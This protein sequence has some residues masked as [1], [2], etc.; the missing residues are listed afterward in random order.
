MVNVRAQYATNIKT[1]NITLASDTV[2]LDSLSLIPNTILLR[3]ASGQVLDT[4]NYDILPFSSL[5]IWKK[6]PAGDSVVASFRTYPYAFANKYF[7]KDHKAY[8]KANQNHTLAPMVYVPSEV[9]PDKLIDFGSLDYNGNFSRGLSFGSNQSVILNSAFNLQL[10]GMLARDLEVTAAITDN[11]IP[12]QPEGNTQ[13]IQEFDK[14][15]IQ[16]RKG[17]HTVIVGDFDMLSPPD[18]FLKYTKKA[19]GG[20]YNGSFGFKQ[21]GTLKTHVAA[22]ISKGKFARNTLA[23]T[24]G[25]QGPYKLVGSNGETYLI[26]LANSEAVYINGQKLTRGA[27]Q[28]YVIDYNLGTVT[29]MPKRIIT[30]D[31]RIVVEFQYSERSYQRTMIDARLDWTSA[32]K[33]A[34]T[35]FDLY[36]EQDSKNQSQQQSLDDNKKKFL[37]SLGDSIDKAFYPG[38]DTVAFDINRILYERHDTGYIVGGRFFPDTFYVYSVDSNKA[39]YSI[40]FADVGLGNG[41][42]LAAQNTAN[43][44]VFIYSTPL[45][46]IR[47]TDTILVPTGQYLPIVKLVT[48]QMHQMYTLGTSYTISKGNVITAEAALS[49][50]NV[51][52]FSSKDKKNDL[53]AAGK[54]SYNGE[55]ITKSDSGK[56]KEK[57]NIEAN[58]EFSQNRFTP[59]ERY[60]NVEFARDFNLNTPTNVTYNEH[61]ASLGATYTFA[62]LGSITY[63]FRTFIQDTVYKGYENFIAG[64]FSKKNF[65]VNFSGS[66]LHSNANVGNSDFIR[67]RGEF[68]YRFKALRGIKT[69]ITFD[70]EINIYRDKLTDTLNTTLSHIWQN[71]SYFIGSSDTTK[72]QFKLEYLLRMEHPAKPN[73]FDQVEKIAHTVNFTGSV[74]SIKNQTLNWTMTYRHL[75]ERDSAKASEDLKNYYLGRVDYTFALLKGMIRSSTLYEIGAGREQKIQLVYL[76]SPTN[77]GDYIWIGTDVSKPK[78]LSD[79]VPA[80]YKT[81]TSYI[82]TF[83]T[84]PEF[85]AI[86]SSTFNEVVNINP[87]ALLKNPKGFGKVISKLS[88]FSSIQLTKKIYAGKDVST[89]NYFNPFP[90][91]KMDTSIVSLTMNSRN[92]LYINRL[93]AKLSGQIDFNYSRS[94]TLLTAGIENRLTQTQGATVRWN[95]YKQL[96]IQSTYTNGIKGNE[97][98]F[99]KT[100]QYNVTYNEVNSELSYLFQSSIRIA[101]SYYYGFKQ[102]TIP[103]YGG[104]FAVINNV[105]LDF[106][107]NRHNKTTVGAKIT[108]SAIGYS[109]K[110]YVNEQAQYAMLEGLKNGNN[111]VWN[112]SFEQRLSQSIQ[113]LL[114][115]DGRQTG[116]DKSVHTGRAE[117]RAIF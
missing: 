10:Q 73:K 13:Q 1:K 59:I 3:T 51:N 71:Y 77:T 84:T 99:Y 75:D 50:N 57:L 107:Y 102:N 90:T 23:I 28:D 63:R 7:N 46:S 52:L 112:V 27:T 88:L 110:A 81:D 82:R 104:Q 91:Q 65:S 26:I 106:K 58:Y 44:R 56:M 16:L 74:V 35:F 15:F 48:P 12:I 18:Y 68:A 49:N 61:I 93:S 47:A 67:P 55:I 94:R 114:S 60:R 100:Q 9:A 24:E 43:G 83:T 40:T 39:R 85:Y 87:A 89:G 2:K 66:Y 32:N 92:S 115:Y 21:Y 79:F 38:I 19:Q 116:S 70:N 5:L 95:I 72:N 20:G 109:D 6:K 36:T 62:N 34:N 11:N 41:K 17:N 117:I 53:G 103:D 64:Q 101:T 22:G 86:N 29:F 33:K 69:G 30:A 14:I 8:V 98:D 31:L 42:Y 76:V 111:F 78:Q 105:G 108:Y 97:S 45:L 96:N 37:A 25:N 80:T 4:S 54:V 113:L